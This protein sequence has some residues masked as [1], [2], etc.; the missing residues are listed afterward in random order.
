MG[1]ELMGG[2]ISHY[3]RISFFASD[4]A[5]ALR[6]VTKYDAVIRRTGIAAGFRHLRW[7]ASKPHA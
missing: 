4:W 2:M 7:G 6:L 3:T 1:D 5:R